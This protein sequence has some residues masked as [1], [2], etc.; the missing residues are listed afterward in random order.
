MNEIE[1]KVIYNED[2]EEFEKILSD[3]IKDKIC[4]IDYGN[5]TKNVI[6][7]SQN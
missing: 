6:K 2:G 1:V 4:T 3:A 7:Y 5:M